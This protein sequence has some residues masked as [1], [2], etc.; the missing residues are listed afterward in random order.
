MLRFYTFYQD[1][2]SY[3]NGQ[4]IEFTTLLLKEPKLNGNYQQI[5]ATL[6]HGEKVYI[7]S[8]RYPKFS[9]GQR[10]KISGKIKQV[11]NSNSNIKVLNSDRTTISMFFPDIELKK[12]N[13]SSTDVLLNPILLFTSNFR[14][15]VITAFKNT[16]SQNEA[17][18]IL[19]VVFGIDEELSKNYK[20]VLQKSGVTHVVAASGMNVTT[21]AG[22]FSTMFLVLLK[23]QWALTITILSVFIYAFLAG[24]DPSI[25]RASIMAMLAVFSQIIGRQSLAVYSLLITGC[26]MLLISPY[27][28]FDVGFQLSFLSTFGLI[29]IRP[30]FDSFTS[31]A[32]LKKNFLYVDLTTTISAQIAALPIL[33]GTFGTY[34]VF[35]IITN[36]LVLWTIPILMILGG[37]SSILGL[38]FEFPAKIMLYFSIPFLSYFESVV[39]LFASFGQVKISSLNWQVTTGYYLV[40][41]AII[42]YFIKRRR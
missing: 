5:T 40:V 9:Y 28:L 12:D 42:L 11:Q 23:R 39:L 41:T 33:L 8:S 14:Q 15:N 13:N 19:G 20:E 4:L 35:S 2:P 31:M 7:N 18:L 24:F 1:F 26:F 6:N 30:I 16:L 10:L 38:V 22:F 17:G 29:Y 3:K 37:V 27:L 32:S 34:S 36:T 25:T 21:V